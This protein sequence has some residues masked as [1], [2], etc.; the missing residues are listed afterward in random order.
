MLLAV[1]VL[2][3]LVDD[4]WVD[5]LLLECEDAQGILHC[6][7]LLQHLPLQMILLVGIL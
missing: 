7:L 4:M 1:C 6:L 5:L 2:L 3:G